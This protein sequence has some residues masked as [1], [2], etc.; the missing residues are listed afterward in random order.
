VGYFLGSLNITSHLL[1]PP[2]Q[3][4]GVT[5]TAVV[6]LITLPTNNTCRGAP[7]PGS[8]LGMRSQ[9]LSNVSKGRHRMGNQFIISRISVI[10]KERKTVGP[11]SLAPTNPH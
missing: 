9:K 5:I 11:K 10:R 2:L 1:I 4:Y 6:Q 8:A 3:F 7:W